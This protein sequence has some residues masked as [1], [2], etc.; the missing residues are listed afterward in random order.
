MD[1][2]IVT[3]SLVLDIIGPFIHNAQVLSYVT[4]VVLAWRIV[5][6]VHG[7]YVA[8]EFGLR[9]ILAVLDCTD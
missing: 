8:G 9:E 5:R 1:L 6:I 2:F 4:W 3:V 7:A